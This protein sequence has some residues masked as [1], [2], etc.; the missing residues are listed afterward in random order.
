MPTPPS[1]KV[2]STRAGG[3]ATAVEADEDE[4]ANS[5]PLFNCRR[6]SSLP[7]RTDKD[8]ML[9]L[10]GTVYGK[11]ISDRKPVFF[12]RKFSSGVVFDTLHILR[13]P[14]CT[15]VHKIIHLCITNL[16]WPLFSYSRAIVESR[17]QKVK[18]A[19]EF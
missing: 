9:F 3:M 6:C 8:V 7:S 10:E 18:I 5:V 14:V 17:G 12:S 15:S 16:K 2:H 19:P 1:I 11:T 4:P 13:M